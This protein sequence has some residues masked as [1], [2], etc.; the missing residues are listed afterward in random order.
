MNKSK[1]ASISLFF[2]SPLTAMIPMPSSSLQRI[3][4]CSQVNKIHIE[5]LAPDIRISVEREQTETP[6]TSNESE[7]TIPRHRHN[8]RMILSNGVTA[9]LTTAITAGV[10]LAIHFTSCKK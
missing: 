1:I 2:I 8:R 5:E 7:D 10:T 3:P 9:L 4:A 6:Q